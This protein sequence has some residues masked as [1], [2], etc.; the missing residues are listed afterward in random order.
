[1]LLEEV[2]KGFLSKPHYM[3]EVAERRNL[4][5]NDLVLI[6]DNKLVRGKWRKARITDV[7][8]G[9]DGKVRK[10]SYK[11]PEAKGYTKVKRSVNSL[12]VLLP[13]E[14]SNSEGL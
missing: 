9:T 13:N 5:I 10:V 11:Q 2:D 12:V 14:E 1:M 3:T 4:Q 6:C 8:P 7:F